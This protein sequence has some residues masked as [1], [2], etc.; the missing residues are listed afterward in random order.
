VGSAEALGERS[1]GLLKAGGHVILMRHMTTTP[2]VG[3]PE[4]FRLGDCS[5]QRNLSETGRAEAQRF[6]ETLR[7]NGIAIARVLSSPWCRCVDSAQLALPEA[8]VE[9]DDSLASFFQNRD[10]SGQR[11]ALQTVRATIA[12]WSGPGNLLMVTHQQN[13]SALAGVSLSQ[14]AML[15]L[16]PKPGGYDIVAQDKP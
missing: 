11:S 12:G 1:I 5:T 7:R 9:T 16:K 6:G 14:G 13:I 10:S 4:G 8:R 2:G 15:I 3:D